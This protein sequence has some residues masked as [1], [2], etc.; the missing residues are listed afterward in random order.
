MNLTRRIACLDLWR[1]RSSGYSAGTAGL[2]AECPDQPPA[3]RAEVLERTMPSERG[4]GSRSTERRRLPVL[5]W[6]RGRVRIELIGRSNRS[7]SSHSS[8]SSAC[9]CA[10]I[11]PA[12]IRIDAT[13]PHTSSAPAFI[14]RRLRSIQSTAITPSASVVSKTPLAPL[15]SAAYGVARRRAHCRRWRA[16]AGTCAT[17]AQLKGQLKRQT[18]GYRRCP[19]AATIRKQQDGIRLHRLQ[20]KREQT[21]ADAFG[22]VLAGTATLMGSCIHH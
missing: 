11:S 17:N 18:V 5:H 13:R 19:I 7:A 8:A 22:L 15:N 14:A 2:E 12:S 3:S 9:R 6:H 20:G 10:G 1:C 21:A 4:G 16:M